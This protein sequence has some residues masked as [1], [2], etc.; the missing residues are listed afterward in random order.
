MV[1]TD[2][3]AC[4]WGLHGGRHSCHMTTVLTTTVTTVGPST[5]SPTAQKSPLMCLVTAAAYSWQCGVEGADVQNRLAAE[6]LASRLI[7]EQIWEQNT[8]NR[9]VRC[10]VPNR[11]HTRGPLTCAFETRRTREN[12]W[13]VAHNPEVAGSNPVPA[14]SVM[15]QDIGIVPTLVRF[16]LFLWGPFGA[17][18]V[19]S[20]WWD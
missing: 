12:T 17:P 4:R 10:N 11:P 19:G 2:M 6:W 7:W 13:C 5:T 9:A 18:V 8:V 3:V 1:Q 15:S 14:T 20:R 16:G